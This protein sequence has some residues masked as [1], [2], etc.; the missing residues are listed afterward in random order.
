MARFP[1]PGG[2]AAGGIPP[3]S[4]RR[5]SSWLPSA[6]AVEARPTEDSTPFS[7]TARAAP[8]RGARRRTRLRPGSSGI[9]SSLAGIIPRRSRRGDGMLARAADSGQTGPGGWYTAESWDGTQPGSGIRAF[10]RHTPGGRSVVLDRHRPTLLG[11]TLHRLDHPRHREAVREARQVRRRLADDR[12]DELVGLDDVRFGVA[13]T[14]SGYREHADVREVRVCRPDDH[15]LGAA[16]LAWRRAEVVKLAG[17]L[18]VERGGPPRADEHE[19][20]R[21]AVAV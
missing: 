9:A 21:V 11:R 13:V 3:V 15:S 6:T 14:G 8:A 19:G 4:A 7:K 10:P 16:R 12:A 18:H 17:A 2:S 20:R 5:C 1:M